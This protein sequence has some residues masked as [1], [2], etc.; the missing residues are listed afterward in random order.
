MDFVAK[1][2]LINLHSLTWMINGPIDK[3]FEKS[4]WTLNIYSDY[5]T[6]N[7][8]IIDPQNNYSQYVYKLYTLL[9]LN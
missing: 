8:E 9:L 3:D 2:K 1:G 7:I 4:L 6:F 5:K